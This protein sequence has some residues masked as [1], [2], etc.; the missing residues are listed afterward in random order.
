MDRTL[1]CVYFSEQTKKRQT[2]NEVDFNNN[3]NSLKSKKYRNNKIATNIKN[4][5]KV[6]HRLPN[7]IGPLI[8]FWLFYL[9]FFFLLLF[10]FQA[11]NLSFGDEKV[12]VFEF[13]KKQWLYIMNDEISW[14]N[15][16]SFELFFFIPQNF[17]NEVK[18]VLW[19]YRLYR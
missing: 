15:Y 17:P 2:L 5:Q 8:L 4:V 11:G 9:R 1:I 18:I 16:A 10:T 7:V 19:R 6:C 13:E 3:C 14:T 12:S